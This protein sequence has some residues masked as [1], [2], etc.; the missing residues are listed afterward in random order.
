V[1]CQIDHITCCG[2][3]GRRYLTKSERIE[4]LKEYKQNLE[5][6][7]KGVEERIVELGGGA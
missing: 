2:P 6:E 5:N 3:S 7:L 1:R 4:L